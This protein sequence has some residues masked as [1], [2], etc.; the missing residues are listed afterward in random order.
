[1]ESTRAIRNSRMML[2]LI[3]GIP[4]IIILAA[5]WL[6][7]FVAR[8][9]LD[10]VDI[11]G[12]SNRGSLVQ[13]PRSLMDPSIIGVDG[14]ALNYGSSAGKWALLVPLPGVKCEQ[15]CENAL[16]TTRQIHIALG[17]GF[18]RVARLLVSNQMPKDLVLDVSALSDN[19]PMPDSFETY[20]K[21]EHRGLTLRSI[22]QEQYQSLFREQAAR[23]D[24]W[25]LVDPAG[26]IMM[27]YNADVNY[28]DVM[29]DIKFL[30]KNSSE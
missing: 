8:G 23:P 28:K 18:N 29:A 9:D 4:I 15:V 27:S 3:A 30:L 1:M 5:T 7:F 20:L 17:K 10:L 25:Y 24:T 13:P 12:T 19:H 6:W 11:L 21:T 16:Y 26:W 14:Q 2:L 22:S